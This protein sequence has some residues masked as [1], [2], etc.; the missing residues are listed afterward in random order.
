MSNNAKPNSPR[1]DRIRRPSPDDALF[2]NSADELA[3][4]MNND[5]DVPVY[6]R[7]ARADADEKPQPKEAST[8]ATKIA[9]P[10][11]V[12]APKPAENS[13]ENSAEAE[14]TAPADASAPEANANVGDSDEATEKPAKRDVY[15]M[16]GR[17]RPQRIEGRSP[18]AAP[19]RTDDANTDHPETD[20]ASDVD[21]TKLDGSEASS[22]S[23]MAA[24]AGASAAA[25]AGASAAAGAG[26]GA[27]T[28]GGSSSAKGDE[29]RW[30][31]VDDAE[32]SE[33]RNAGANVGE[34]EIPANAAGGAVGGAGA[35]AAS[36]AGA[37][38]TGAG[39]PGDAQGADVTR[40]PGGDET[41]GAGANVGERENPANAAGGAGGAGAEDS[42]SVA[43]RGTTSFGLFLL[44]VVLGAYLL[45]RGL[46]TL[47]AFGGD[48]GLEVFQGQLESYN[49]TDILAI[50]IPVAEI[51]AGGLL[52][53]GLLT[54]F[55]AA[56]ATVVAGFM[57]FHNLNG[58]QGSLWPYGLNPYVQLWAALTVASISIIFVGP[59]RISLDRSR[60]WATR[61]L[62]SAWIFF[63]VAAAATAGL[64]LGVGGGN[65]FN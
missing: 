51:V 8:G 11:D 55:G 13:A 35:G 58:F 39:V 27:T 48:P 3:D 14:A 60:G 5:I 10:A 44:R 18:D 61:P 21:L 1:P 22:G 53:L 6:R 19:T 45:V 24:A 42:Q 15:A 57:T 49:F 59:G 26:L 65:P 37:G 31:K 4:D 12:D 50:G 16:L 28:A 43:K 40:N 41:T 33:F 17:A 46:Q 25:G 34:R 20:S 54:P 29:D 52:L 47:F 62:A 63:V 7:D 64:W 9:K 23:G 30:G 36:A 38:V 56:V 32:T 2:D